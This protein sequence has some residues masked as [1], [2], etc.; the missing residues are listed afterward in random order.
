MVARFRSWRQHIRTH[1]VTTVLISLFV[2]LVVLVILGGYKLNWNWT[3]FNG[4][5]K[6]GKTLWDWMQLLFIPVV[7]AV[8]G[9]WFNHRERKA[10]ELRAENEQKAA[11]LRAE[12]ER[13]I[14][15][16]RA[17]AEQEIS[18]DNQREAALQAY[19]NEMSELLLHENLRKSTEDE[20]VRNIARV[21]TL[22]L[23]RRC[24][25]ERKASVLQFLHE[26]GL[27]DK[28]KCIIGLSG[29]DLSKAYLGGL[30]LT[31]AN[32][33]RTI[34]IGANLMGTQLMGANLSET[35]L[36]GALLTSAD[37]T[38]ANL[39]DASISL[40]NLAGKEPINTIL[41]EANLTNA[42]LSGARLNGADLRYTNLTGADLTGTEFAGALVTEEQ[43][44]KAR[45]L[46]G[47]TMPDRSIHP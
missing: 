23:L 18:L 12:A 41:Y 27:I 2:T 3:G 22:T 37:L 45:S 44:K 10:A 21:R 30:V 47:A 39:V 42:N 14:E 28:D 46:E 36:I 5:N 19:I 29:A 7:L 31:N 43:L 15:Q 8:A 17:K 20:E 32:L 9:F 24:D 26:S 38:G 6:S 25:A 34:L 33:S 40:R 11:E 4:N 1:P 35:T 16:Q 13:E